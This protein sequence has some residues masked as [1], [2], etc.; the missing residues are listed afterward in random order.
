MTP[1]RWRRVGELFHE[2]LEVAPEERDGWA[3]RICA[4]DTELRQELVSLLDNDRAAGGGFVQGRVKA[5][6][7]SFQAESSPTAKPRRGG[8]TGWCGSWGKAAWVRS[9]WPSATMTSI[10][11]R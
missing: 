11:R 1:E 6:V 8:P 7:A 5:A 9:T 4:G 10:R 3:H 2:A